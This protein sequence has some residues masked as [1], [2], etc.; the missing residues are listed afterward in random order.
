MLQLL[1]IAFNVYDDSASADAC[2]LA[3]AHE[4][5]LVVHHGD[6]PGMISRDRDA[7]SVPLSKLRDK[8]SVQPSTPIPR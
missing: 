5:E 8:Q 6:V 1:R 3:E 2:A 7:T 4:H